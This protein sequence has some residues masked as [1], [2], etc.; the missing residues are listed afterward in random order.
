MSLS[1]LGS[2][3]GRYFSLVSLVPS[4]ITVLY[5]FFL[6]NSG[7]WSGPPVWAAAWNTL[8]GA[9][10]GVW[11]LI[12]GLALALGLAAHPLQFP[13][14]QA[15]E[16]YWGRTV[17]ARRLW[18]DRSSAHARKAVHNSDLLN[19]LKGLEPDT[20]AASREAL[21]VAGLRV[22]VDR[23]AARY[24]QP[25][26]DAPSPFM[27][28]RLGNVLRRYELLAGAPY[29]LSG[30][31]AVP[32]LALVADERDVRYLDDQRATLDLV[33]RLSAMSLLACA[34]TVV[35]LWND[36]LW[37]LLALVPYALGYLFYRGAVA[38]AH[39]YGTAMAA[40]IA[41]NRDALYRRLRLS[42]PESAA[43]E[44]RRNGSSLR[45]LLG[46]ERTAQAEYV[47]PDQSPGA[48]QVKDLAGGGT[49]PAG[50]MGS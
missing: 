19:H 8:E 17:L 41:L 24:P 27:P 34:I 38:V 47:D 5:V 44:R 32:Y 37:L 2:S 33:V 45:Y 7:A 11:T 12:V 40:L 10:P 31:Q 26:P 39:E 36:G 3:I 6:V 9:G 42:L 21:W 22:D 1:E 28:T 35:F 15:Y 46:L 50:R 4:T 49:D 23:A 48:T 29:G 13:L 43:A 16:G 20:D 18:L 25:A 14:V 30:V